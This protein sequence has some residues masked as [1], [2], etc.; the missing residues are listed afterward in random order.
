MSDTE[1]PDR[2]DFET[3]EAYEIARL[4]ASSLV[5]DRPDLPDG[6]ELVRLAIASLDGGVN[7]SNPYKTLSIAALPDGSLDYSL[8]DR[9]SGEVQHFAVTIAPKA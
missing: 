8:T 3:D 6:V 1:S 5:P 4:D 7:G 2:A 9:D